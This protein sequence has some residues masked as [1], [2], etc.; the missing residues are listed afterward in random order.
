MTTILNPE[1]NAQIKDLLRLDP[2]DKSALYAADRIEQLE[3]ENKRL[4]AEIELY[5]EKLDSIKNERN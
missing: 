2:E 3:E 5:R 4:K 1:M